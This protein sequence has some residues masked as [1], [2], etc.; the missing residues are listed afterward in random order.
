[1]HMERRVTALEGGTKQST[2]GD[3]L[4]AMAEVDAGGIVDWSTIIASPA[5]LRTLD[6][7]GEGKDA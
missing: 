6:Q 3:M 7:I 1:M 4:D 5:L 2:I